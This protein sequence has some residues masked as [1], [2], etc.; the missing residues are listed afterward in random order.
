[1][2]LMDGKIVSTNE[3]VK[4]ITMAEYNA[5]SEEERNNGTSY[6]ISDYDVYEYKKLVKIGVVIGDDAKLSG[7]ADGTI[8]GAIIDIYNRLNGVSFTVGANN[9][10]SFVYDGTP[11]TAVDPVPLP[12]DMTD[13]EKIAHYQEAIGDESGLNNLGFTNVIAA[14]RDI[15]AKLNGIQFKYD[16]ESATLKMI[17]SDTNPK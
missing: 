11:P 15:Y 8:V 4:T 2:I 16:D 3:Q 7:Y 14:I 1:M 13:Y 9:E 12:E 6:F 5:L 17:Y 10:V